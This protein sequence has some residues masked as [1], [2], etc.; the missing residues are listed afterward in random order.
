METLRIEAANAAV[1][2]VADLLTHPDDL[3]KIES[4]RSRI[5]AEQGAIAAQLR[6][7]VEQQ[8]DD[9]ERG[10]LVLQRSQEE[11][12]DIRGLLTNIQELCADSQHSIDNYAKITQVNG[13]HP[14]MMI[15]F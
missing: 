1:Q 8:T 13:F 11:T 12:E 6:T 15:D 5:S 2:R 7:V 10:L 3:L 14:L 4:I 9:A